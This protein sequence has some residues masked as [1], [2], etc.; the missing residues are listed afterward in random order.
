MLVSSHLLAEL[1]QAVDDVVLIDHGRLVA[2]GSA[3]DLMAH[4]GAAS[5]EELYLGIVSKG[6]PS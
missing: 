4:H 1:A 2:E 5:L 6:S 3:A